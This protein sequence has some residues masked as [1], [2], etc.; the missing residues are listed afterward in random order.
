MKRRS[1]AALL[2]TLG[3]TVG[4]NGTVVFA[5]E[6]PVE[7]QPAEIQQETEKEEK[8]DAGADESRI[9][10]FT[11]YTGMKVT[12]DANVSH[13][14]V[15]EVEDAVLTGVKYRTTDA[16]GGETLEAVSFEGNVELKQPEE[17][18]KYTSVAADVF[19]GNPLVTYVKLP[20]GVTAV[21]ENGFKDCTGLK[22]VYLPSTVEEIGAGAFEGCTAMTQLSLPKSVTVIG[23]RAFKGDKALQTV[24]FRDTA[25]MG[26][27]S[28]G[29][30]AFEGCA[31]L[32]EINVETKNG[33]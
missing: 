16:D 3:L 27:L 33:G 7:T 22:S 28:V 21:A 29:A 32:E 18:E 26:Q 2:L 4:G 6:T 5:A 17:G 11:D 12:Y 23:E 8:P 14:Y 19:G 31:E 24:Q 9:V 13:H 1:S 25:D 30:H 20:A 10:S 15:Y